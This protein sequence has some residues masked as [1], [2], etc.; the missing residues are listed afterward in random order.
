MVATASTFRFLV[1]WTLALASVLL[2]G[3]VPN[4]ASSAPTKTSYGT[5]HTYDSQGAST[6][7]TAILRAA[8]LAP[9]LVVEGTPRALTSSISLCVATKGGPAATGNA[10]RIDALTRQAAEQYPNLAGKVH[11]H[12]VTP[13]YLGGQAGWAAGGDRRR[14]P[15]ADYQRVPAVGAVR[16]TT[17]GCSA[18]RGGPATGLQ[19]VPA[20]RVG[21]PA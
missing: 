18:A 12:H 19:Q 6:T 1:A 4:A 20:T 21:G 15:P 16:W 9:R 3:A 14:L 11:K 13:K 17:A 7:P 2:L 8:T 5:G 10:G